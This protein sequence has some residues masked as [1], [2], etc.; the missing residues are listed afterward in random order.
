MITL[1]AGIIFVVL[2]LSLGL[3]LGL[4]LKHHSSAPK[5]TSISTSTPTSSLPATTATATATSVP[6]GLS[7]DIPA[8]R[9]DPSEYNLDLSWDINAAPTTRV[10]H[11]TVSTIVAA[12]D[13]RSRRRELDEADNCRRQSLHVCN[14]RAIPRTGHS[15]QRGRSAAHQRD[16]RIVGA[17]NHALAWSLSKRHQLDGWD[18]GNHTGMRLSIQ[19]S[20]VEEVSPDRIVPNPCRPKLPLQLYHHGPVRHVLV[21]F[22]LLDSIHRR[23]CGSTH[24]SLPRRGHN[25]EVL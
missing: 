11:L 16:Q 10:Y 25:P 13:G 2:A 8:W 9:R 12:P 21:S 15:T 17:N 3:G 22:T 4:G 23:D 7:R 20:L 24:H 19:R 5:V 14:Q 1:T 18:G 6:V